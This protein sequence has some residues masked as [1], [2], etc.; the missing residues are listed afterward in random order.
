MQV[1][2]NKIAI[3]FD[4]STGLAMKGDKL[5]GFQ[6]AGADKKFVDAAATID[7][8]RV[9]VT[10]DQVAEPQHVRFGFTDVAEPNLFNAAGLPASPFRTDED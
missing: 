1:E 4:H 7:G 3:T 6:I 8:E 10:S 2:G 9:I 5:V